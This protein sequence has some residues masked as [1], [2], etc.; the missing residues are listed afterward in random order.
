MNPFRWSF[1]AQFLAGFLVCVGL[2]GAALYTQ[3][4]QHQIPCPLCSFQRGAFALLGLVFLIGGLH[5]PRSRGGRMVYGLLGLVPALI[6]IGIAGRHV[7]LQHLP[8]D[9]VPACG[10]DLAYMMEAFPLGDVL[11]QVLTGSG[12]CAEVTWRLLGLSMPEWSLLWFVVLTL[13][14]LMAAF[15]RRKRT[16]LRELRPS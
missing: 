4:Y 10:P 1:R 12:E 6:G 2:L 11:R 13:W 3:Y 15:R 16:L 14:L 9:K 7:W 8:A 5:G